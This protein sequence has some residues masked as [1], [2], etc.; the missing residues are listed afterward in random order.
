MEKKERADRAAK[1]LSIVLTCMLIGSFLFFVVG[2]IIWQEK[3]EISENTFRNFDAQWFQEMPDG[4]LNEVAIPG[5]CDVEYGEW[6]TIVTQLSPELESTSLCF[7]SLQQ[8]MKFYVGDELRKEYSTLKSQKFGKTSTMAYVI[9]PLY[10]SDA[11]K[12]LRVEFMSKSSYANYVGDIYMGETVDIK[13]RL[14][15]VYAPGL[16]IAVFLFIVSLMV[17]IISYVLQRIYKKDVALLYLGDALLV[18]S[19]WLIAESKIRQF[20]FPSA[21]IAMWMGFLLIALLPYPFASY[22]NKVQNDRY[23]KAYRLI[24]MLTAVNFVIVVVLQVF[25]IRD[26]FESMTLSHIN[27]GLLLITMLVTI[28]RDIITGKVKEYREVAIGLGVLIVAGVFE[29][30][31]V[32][33]V[34]AFLNGVSLCLGLVIL[35]FTASVRTL[36]DFWSVEKEKQVAIAAADSKAKFLANMSHEIRTPI[37][38]VIGM[39]EMIL[40]ENNDAT[41]NEYAGN[42]KSASQMLLA[43]INDVLDFS[44]IDAGKLQ[45]VE[46]DYSLSSLLNDVI[47]GADIRAKQKQLQLELDIDETMPSVLYGDEIRIKQVL[48]NILSNAVKYTEKGKVTFSAKGIYKDDK[49]V[50]VL[51]VK[52]TGIGISKEDMGHLFDSFQR[53]EMSKNRYIQGSGLG[54]N[55]AKQLIELMDGT[56]DVESEHGKGSCFTVTIPQIIV[57]SKAMG[58]PSHKEETATI[59]K[60]EF[61]APDAKVLVVDD[62]RMNLAVIRAL[63]KHTQV[64]LD[65]ASSGIE[66]LNMTKNKKYDLIL[67]DHM[68]PEPDGI[69]TLHMLR[70]DE[71]NVNQSTEVVVLTANAIEG[72]K[73]QYL[74]E[75]FADYLSKPIEIERLEEILVKYLQ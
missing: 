17:S 20:V 10:S 37:N 36:R 54:L 31:L 51:A 64:Q 24:C 3:A 7:R 68:M 58:T 14:Y 34:D 70:E 67:M 61:V 45:I 15:E 30:S 21:T 48:N 46:A 11:G 4:T 13:G 40:R 52:D 75:G 23:N 41:I 71:D 22:I 56:I 1:I 29:I 2:E 59:T 55:I 57:D 26:F 47:L 35:L 16:I 5:I 66:C 12:T 69:Q 25:N 50:L 43:L 44:K 73:E 42:I 9:F 32:Y 49:I 39:N 28:I 62:N 19:G 18:A 60:T 8:E 74:Q 6:G 33:M 65:M 53:F 38:V 27:I 72:M 63:M